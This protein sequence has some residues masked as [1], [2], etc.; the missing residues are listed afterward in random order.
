MSL[1]IVLII[2][3]TIMGIFAFAIFFLAKK[4]N[5]SMKQTVDASPVRAYKNG[6]QEK[7]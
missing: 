2:I 4:N 1:P 7:N 3:V 6:E 5:V